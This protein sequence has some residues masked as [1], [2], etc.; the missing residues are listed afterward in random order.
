MSKL[1][2]IDLDDASDASDDADGVLVFVAAVASMSTAV[3]SIL[4]EPPF[5]WATMYGGGGYSV[6]HWLPRGRKSRVSLSLSMI[7]RS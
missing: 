6:A 5:A 3:G 2:M 7:I 4:M 1:Q